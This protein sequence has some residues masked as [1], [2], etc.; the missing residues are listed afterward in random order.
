MVSRIPSLNRVRS[1]EIIAVEGSPLY[2][3]TIDEIP[4][5]TSINFRLEDLFPG[6]SQWGYLNFLDVVNNNSAGLQIIYNGRESTPF[7]V[8][9]Y[10]SRS[11]DRPYT[12]LKFRNPA[13]FYVYN[14]VLTGQRLA[15]S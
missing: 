8:S 10:N 7:F 1:R 9:S 12:H 3:Y 2:S 13:H 5:Q 14:I 4:G 11:F 6:A 15:G